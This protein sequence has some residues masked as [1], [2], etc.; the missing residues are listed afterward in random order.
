MLDLRPPRLHRRKHTL[1][2]RETGHVPW[3][4]PQVGIE[5]TTN[6]L[7]A[8]RS[9]TELLRIYNSVY[10]KRLKINSLLFFAAFVLLQPPLSKGDIQNDSSSPFALG[11]TEGDGEETSPPPFCQRRQPSASPLVKPKVIERR[12]APLCD[13]VGENRF[14]LSSKE[15]HRRRIDDWS[16]FAKT[17]PPF[18]EKTS[19]SC[20]KRRLCQRETG[21][22]PCRLWLHRR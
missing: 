5:P 12:R 7:T 21:P 17:P 20:A 15:S 18:R 10:Q 14:W 19:P 13:F 4:S 22:L 1:L 11:F 9:T 6:R 3:F 2:T 16:V 8:D